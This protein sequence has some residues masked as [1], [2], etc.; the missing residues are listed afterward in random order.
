LNYASRAAQRGRT[1]TQPSYFLKPSSS[2][3]ASGSTLER[4]AGTEL[5]AFEGE[6]ALVIGEP[7][8]RVSPDDGWRHV[9]SVT[10][11]N[12]FGLYDLRA[13]DKGSNVRS[14]GGDG[15]TPLGPRL[16]DA[17]SVDPDGLR[18][19][20]W[21]N[22]H[23]VQE[24]TSDTLLFPFGQLIADLS[25]LLTLE[26]G[27]VILTGTPAGSSVV[28]PGD[29]VEVE[30]DAPDAA[31][32]PSSGRLATTI[33]EGTVP[34][35]DFG[36]KPAADDHQRIEAWGDARAAGVE[37]TRT[38][39]AETPFEL[40]DELRELLGSVGVATL[41]VQL[42]KRGYTDVFLEGVHA[43]RPGARVVG[44]AR[45]LRFIPFRPDLFARK[46]GGYNAQKAAFDTV[47]SGEVLV[48]EARGERGTGTVGDLLAL[49]AQVRGAAGIVTDGGTRDFDVVAALALPTFSQGPHP[50]VLGRRH[51]P[52][53]TDV[54]ISCGGA[55]IEP[56]DIIVG[57]GDGV[58]VIPPALAWEVAR[59]A[60][61]QEQEEEWVAAQVAA[62]A[63]VDGLFPMNA[64][65]RARYEAD[66]AGTPGGAG[67]AGTPGGEASP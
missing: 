1:P 47:G 9:A 31:G 51:V 53:E 60:A 23:V 21:V 58:I 50:S 17:A 25:Q 10:A 33:I 64:E 42:R 57:D 4:P 14:K 32:A 37:P 39:A 62:G 12:D 2:L 13:A 63:S 54:A 56:G 38:D 35:G 24:D 16:I 40:T 8:R 65:W 15:F 36:S 52:W 46:G 5:L 66:L 41:S 61:V 20:T 11:A 45:T 30:V 26:T 43:N 7:A 3:A 28:E 55:A 59:E 49:R 48:I 27:D 34:F 18:V 44:R 6:I 67:E 22:G 29:V 19:R